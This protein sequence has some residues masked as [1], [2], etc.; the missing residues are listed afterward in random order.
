MAQ[1]KQT[2]SSVT[3]KQKKNTTKRV[4]PSSPV[5]KNS[6]LMP[7]ASK[8]GPPKKK[9]KASSGSLPWTE[10]RKHSFIVSV[11]RTGTRR[12]PPKFEVRAAAKTEKKINVKSG[13][14]AQHYACAACG[15]EF[16]S[17]GIEVDHISPIVS[18]EG[19]TTWDSYIEN[20]YC[21]KE[22][23]QVLCLD[24]HKEKTK[25]ERAAP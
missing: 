1:R 16:P 11:L 13:R 7:D 19:F 22:N 25:G 6:S 21:S 17:T 18:S 14:M 2:T 24:C 10:A 23:L 8:S 20:M 15:N 3:V 4:F 5:K 12:W 9:Q